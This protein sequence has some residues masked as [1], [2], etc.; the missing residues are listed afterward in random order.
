MRDVRITSWPARTPSWRRAAWI[1]LALLLALGAAW[2]LY[3]R[4]AP[5]STTARP[6]IGAPM[7]VVVAPVAQGDVN[8]TFN[9]LGTVTPLATVT[10][11]T[12][13]S[14]QLMQ[15]AFQEG[16]LVHQGD[17]LA[18]I[19]PRPYEFA[20][21]QAQGQLLHDQALLKQAQNDL[22]RYRVLIKQDS[23]AQQTVDTQEQLVR[24]Y[25]GT[26]QS[27]QSQVD[28][29]KL[30][31][32]YCHIVAPVTGRVGL[33]QVDQG[34]YVTPGD[35]NGIVVLTE[36]Q[37]ITV[38]F[39]LPEDNL[40][41]I[42]KQLSA[43]ATLQVTAYDRSNTTELATGKLVTVDNQIDTTTGTIR[44][45]AQF[46]NSDGVL[47]PNQ[48]VNIRLL[49]ST[50]HNATVVPAAAVQRGAP[51][52]F[53][54]VAKPDDTVTVQPV[55]LGPADGDKVSIAAGLSVGQ[56]VVVDGADKLRDNAKIAR[57]EPSTNITPPD[58]GSLQAPQRRAGSG[59]RQRQ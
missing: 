47:F 20:L 23:I 36:M 28:T 10:V 16:Q 40:P 8:I 29:A 14:G 33:R 15:I 7:P 41:A 17:L 1:V 42:V 22:A 44:M 3:K 52:T 59:A 19:D 18:I 2:W 9:A 45:R 51:G 11:R 58:T 37:P 43:G 53:V 21:A 30:N 34:N 4:A 48:F 27:D 24:Q 13:I 55:K 38:I 12:Q 56:E 46:D 6:G 49:V 39:T 35:A 57:R 50:L 54:Y 31:I 25:E 5:Q 26:V 32:A